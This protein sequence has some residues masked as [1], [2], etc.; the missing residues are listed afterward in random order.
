M[1][2]LITSQS[3]SGRGSASA[4][5]HDGGRARRRSPREL[6]T[7]P[8]PSEAVASSQSEQSGRPSPGHLVGSEIR[9]PAPGR[10]YSGSGD[11][12]DSSSSSTTTS[13]PRPPQAANDR[14]ALIIAADDHS[15]GGASGLRSR[16]GGGGAHEGP[17]L[18]RKAVAPRGFPIAPSELATRKPAARHEAHDR[19][20]APGGRCAHHVETGNRGLEA[21]PRAPGYPPP[22][23]DL[24]QELV[25]EERVASDVHPYPW[26]NIR[27]ST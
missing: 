20:E 17:M 7:R 5:V 15:S 24:T 12:T 22:S 19:P 27:W 6:E 18:S 14:E 1:P 25:G 26:P 21:P 16:R 4:A 2:S 8:S 3:A 11:C 10:S 23:P 9:P 13:T